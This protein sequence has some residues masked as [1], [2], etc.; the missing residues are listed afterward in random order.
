MFVCPVDVIF[1]LGIKDLLDIR[2]G[3]H[4]QYLVG[5]SGQ[6]LLEYIDIACHAADIRGKYFTENQYTHTITNTN[7]I[8]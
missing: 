8:E 4:D 7:I 6:F 2:G 3:G 1:H 5:E